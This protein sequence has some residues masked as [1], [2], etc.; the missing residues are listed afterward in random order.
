VWG[1]EIREV[2]EHRKQ[3]DIVRYTLLLVG[4]GV[5][6]QEVILVHGWRKESVVGSVKKLGLATKYAESSC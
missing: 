5:D 6:R 4:G 1:W 2:L 3:V